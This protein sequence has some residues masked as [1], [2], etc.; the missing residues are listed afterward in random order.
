MTNMIKTVAIEYMTCEDCYN[1]IYAC[2]DCNE[3][4][5]DYQII[6]CDDE[7]HYCE[8]CQENENN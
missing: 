2:S 5:E 7:S 8:Q 4:F 1:T 3:Y 6:Y